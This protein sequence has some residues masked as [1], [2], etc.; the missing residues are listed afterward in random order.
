RRNEKAGTKFVLDQKVTR[1]QVKASDAD[2]IVVATGA[3]PQIEVRGADLPHVVSCL[4][5]FEGKVDVGKRV[6]ILGDSGAAISTALLLLHRGGHQVTMVGKAKKPG[7]DVNPSYIWRYMKKLKD[8]KAI[9]LKNTEVTEITPQ[10][11]KVKTPEGEQ[12]VETDTVVVAYLKSNQELCD[13][14]KRIYTL[15]DAITPRR[16]SSAINDGYRMGMRL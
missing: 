2:V 10:G 9:V 1:E 6:V 11:V 5:V 14:R 15:G 16:G 7:Q 13:A 12:L 8:E 4:D 3:E